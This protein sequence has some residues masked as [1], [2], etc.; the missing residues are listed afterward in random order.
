M[1]LD[2]KIWHACNSSPEAG[3]KND[4]EPI[5]TEIMSEKFPKWVKINPQIY[6]AQQIPGQKGKKK[7]H[8]TSVK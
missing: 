1:A 2:P 7:I 6:K 8:A 3:G 4:A 5:C